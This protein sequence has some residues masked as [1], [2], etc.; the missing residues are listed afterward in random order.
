MTPKELLNTIKERHQKVYKTPYTSN[1]YDF[2][3][4]NDYLYDKLEYFLNDY[5]KMKLHLDEALEI[6]KLHNEQQEIVN[7]NFKKWQENY[8][9]IETLTKELLSK[10][11]KE[12]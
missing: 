3:T 8:Y 4:N 2:N 9:K 11:G 10:V 7:S 6:I 5:E 12:E 1:K